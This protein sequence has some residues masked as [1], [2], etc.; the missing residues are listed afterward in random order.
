MN[1][2]PRTW[3]T[4]NKVL[5]GALVATGLAGA[6]GN[7]LPRGGDQPEVGMTTNPKEEVYTNLDAC[8][9][10][11]DDFDIKS[12]NVQTRKATVRIVGNTCVNLY[13]EDDPNDARNLNL[14]RGS[15]IVACY[16][17][18]SIAFRL[19]TGEQSGASLQLSDKAYNEF[20][21]GDPDAPTV[22]ACP[23]PSH[24]APVTPYPGEGQ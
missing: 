15:T 21:A 12:F 2:D 22:P 13:R 9:P 11:V 14:P 18:D 20:A 7:V 1:R 17:S 19:L 4:K 3:K 24:Q 23:P 16:D 8:S 5:A 10:K 6:W